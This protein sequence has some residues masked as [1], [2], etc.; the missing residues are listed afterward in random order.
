MFSY[1][2]TST[3]VGAWSIVRTRDRGTVKLIGVF[4]LS[5]LGAAKD[6]IG[7]GPWMAHFVSDRIGL[8][9]PMPCTIRVWNLFAVWFHCHGLA[10][11]DPILG[12]VETFLPGG[13]VSSSTNDLTPQHLSREPWWLVREYEQE[14][15]TICSPCRAESQQSTA[16]KRYERGTTAAKLF[17]SIVMVGFAVHVGLGRYERRRWIGVDSARHVTDLRRSTKGFIMTREGWSRSNIGWVRHVIDKIGTS[18]LLRSTRAARKTAQTGAERFERSGS[19]AQLAQCVTRCI[20]GAA[21]LCPEEDA[22]FFRDWLK[23]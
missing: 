13:R 2:K 11:F 4:V 7:M 16:S 5:T 1:G 19:A 9:V 18:G 23:Y 15:W 17:I 14:N 22:I 10:H 12:N 8:S 3:P 6:R 21:H 20:R